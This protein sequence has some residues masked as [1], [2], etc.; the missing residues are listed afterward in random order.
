MKN[1]RLGLCF[2]DENDE[3]ISKR[4][5]GTDWTINMEQDK[6]IFYNDIDI[7][8]EATSTLLENIRISLNREIIKEMLDELKS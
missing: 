5:L 3:V 4:V 7:K 1:V 8:G 2:L 6:R